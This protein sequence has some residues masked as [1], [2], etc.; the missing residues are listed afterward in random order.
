[1][2]RN[3]KTLDKYLEMLIRKGLLVSD[4]SSSADFSAEIK[5]LSYNSK[6]VSPGTLFV[7]KV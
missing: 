5:G 6:A 7:C 2:S 3:I 4:N 1:M